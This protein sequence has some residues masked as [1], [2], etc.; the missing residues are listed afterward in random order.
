[1]VVQEFGDLVDDGEAAEEV[2]AFGRCEGVEGGG[3]DVVAASADVVDVA[4]D[5]GGQAQAHDAAVGGV[6]FA[7]EEVVFDECGDEGGDAVGGQAHVGGGGFDGDVGVAADEAQE[8]GLGGAD[9]G[10]VEGSAGDAYL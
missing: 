10:P 7:D 3:D 8:F 2:V 5:V 4:L 1:M 9:A 6:G